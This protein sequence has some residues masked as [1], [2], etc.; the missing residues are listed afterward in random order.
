MQQ[1][2]WKKN[3]SFRSGSPA[4]TLLETILSITIILSISLLIPLFFQC[5]NKTI[6]L[7]NID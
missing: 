4:F 2:N 1:I 3:V 7:S 6:Q 5:Y